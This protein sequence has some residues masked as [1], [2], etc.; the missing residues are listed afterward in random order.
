[1]NL[2]THVAIDRDAHPSPPNTLS[3]ARSAPEPIDIFAALG[4]VGTSRPIQR[5]RADVLRYGRSNA[6]VLVQGETGSGKELV[7]RALH[8][9]SP[10][11]RR[12]FVAVNVAT[13]RGEM[14]ASELFGHERGAFTGAFTRHRGLFEQAHGGTLFLDELGELDARTQADLLRVLE[15][16]EVRPLGSERA[17]VVD[18]R[19]VAATHRDL[20]AIVTAG[21]FRADLYYRLNVLSVTVPTLRER[22]ADLPVLVEHL[23][24][25]LRPEVGDRRLSSDA[26]ALLSRH[27]FPGNIRQLLNVLRRA[28]VRDDRLVVDAATI[29]DALACEPGTVAP[30]LYRTPA[31]D[32]SVPAVAEAMQ[33]S[34]GSIS[35]AARRLGIARSTLRERLHASRRSDAVQI[36]SSGHPPVAGVAG[37]AARLA[38]DP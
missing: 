26:L 19:I 38:E 22:R 2:D 10:R 18:V 27:P 23:L 16:G 32:L 14:L 28:L 6:T 12:S 37:A 34:G 33:A 11:A 31:R 35:A 13:L 30:I 15:T 20:G 21:C 36:D 29:A 24:A 3:T 17:R 5:L 9:A 25:R 1:M 8:L 4:L 7:A